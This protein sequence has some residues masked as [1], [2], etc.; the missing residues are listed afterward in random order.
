MRNTPPEPPIEQRDTHRLIEDLCLALRDVGVW[1]YNPPDDE[2]R[3]PAVRKVQQIHAELEKRGADFRPRVARLSEETKWQMGPLL[4]ECLAFPGTVPYVRESDGVRRAFRCSVCR[5]REF[6]DRTGLLLCD[7]CLARA[8]ESIR[9]RMPWGGLLLFR[10]YNESKWCKHADAETV[11]M[12][13]D[14]YDSLDYAWCEKCI[15][16]EQG[17]RRARDAR[18]EVNRPSPH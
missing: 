3:A 10:T 13:F 14:D 4:Q 16:E 11:M 8:T 2:R 17:R 7:V 1:D 12:A 6:P 18:R 15:A 9:N 5:G